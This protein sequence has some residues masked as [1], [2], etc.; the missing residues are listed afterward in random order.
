MESFLSD[1][2]LFYRS[3]VPLD[4]ER[5]RSLTLAQPQRFGFA[6]SSHLVPAV[7]DEFGAACRHL[8]ILFLPDSLG[9]TPVFLSGLQPGRS[10]LVDAEGA[11]TGRYLPA[12]LRRYPF[13]LGEVEGAEPLICLDDTAEAVTSEDRHEAPG[14]VQLFGEAGTDSPLLLEHV[15]LVIEY[16]AAARRTTAFGRILQDLALLRPL[17]V[18]GQDPASGGRHALHG[19]LGVDETALAAL[20]AASFD[21]LRTEGWLGPI[22]AH[23]VSLRAVGDFARPFAALASPETTALEAAA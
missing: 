5:H 21:R 11:W 20:P 1:L 3:V 7:V 23:L 22:H 16:A 15:R 14:C 10:A 8:P 2:P 12:Y 18:E 19:V 17:T 6:R 13:I 9:P 4:R